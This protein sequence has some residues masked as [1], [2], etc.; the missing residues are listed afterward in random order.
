VGDSFAQIYDA[1]QLGFAADGAPLK[2]S[3]AQQLSLFL[4]APLAFSPAEGVDEAAVQI[5]ARLEG[6]K[7]V[8]WVISTAELL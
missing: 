6:K 4:G 7:L 2:A 1:P 5:A 8:L 3:M